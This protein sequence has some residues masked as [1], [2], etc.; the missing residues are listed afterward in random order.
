MAHLHER[1]YANRDIKLQNLFV[2]NVGK[3]VMADFG[4]S[5]MLQGGDNRGLLQTKLGT[6]SYMPPEVY[7]G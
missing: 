7:N 6:P 4:F 2:N 1:G 5:K 3:I